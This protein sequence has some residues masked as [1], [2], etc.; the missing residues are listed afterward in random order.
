MFLI[1]KNR[2]NMPCCLEL[3]YYFCYKH[4]HLSHT[5]SHIHTVNHWQSYMSQANTHTHTLMEFQWLNS[6]M[7]RDCHHSWLQ[8]TWKMGYL[9]RRASCR[10]N[11]IGVLESGMKVWILYLQM[12]SR[13]LKAGFRCIQAIRHEVMFSGREFYLSL[14]LPQGGRVGVRLTC[15]HLIETL[16]LVSQTSG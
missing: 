9:R 10:G 12:A 6:M 13:C 7:V 15:L 1:N 16:A 5:L 14:P 2:P 4:I 8:E 3:R 11:K